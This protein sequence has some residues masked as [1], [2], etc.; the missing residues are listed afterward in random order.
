MRITVGRYGKRLSVA[1]LQ[2]AI[3]NLDV[4]SGLNDLQ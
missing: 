4:W 2:D 1:K 3:E